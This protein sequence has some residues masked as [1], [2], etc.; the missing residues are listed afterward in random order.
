MKKILLGLA[1]LV[2]NGCLP[3][4]VTYNYL[5]KNINSSGGHVRVYGA[6]GDPPVSQ[7]IP[8]ANAQC[9]RFNS[10]SRATNLTQPHRGA[11]FSG[12]EYSYW[13]YDCTTEKQLDY[14]DEAK[15]ACKK[16]GFKEGT[17]DFSNC[18]LELVKKQSQPGNNTIVIQ[19]DGNS[20][21]E[22]M[23]RGLEMLKGRG[24]SPTMN[25]PTRQ[26]C[27]TMV[28]SRNPYTT[29]EVCR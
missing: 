15:N 5:E 2:L 17:N 8:V 7:I 18:T 27:T 24:G 26:I 22:L 1:L 10:Q 20:S 11:M 13:H 4:H 21:Q 23:D 29:K 28:I 19:N 3:N 9:Q 14:I 6:L 25:A 16:I 12:S